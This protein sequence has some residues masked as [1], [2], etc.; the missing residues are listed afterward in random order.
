MKNQSTSK[1]DKPETHFS[2][3]TILEN[4][5]KQ[6]KEETLR[7]ISDSALSKFRHAWRH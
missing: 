7:W 2:K 4:E 1:S 5:R 6:Q 3:M